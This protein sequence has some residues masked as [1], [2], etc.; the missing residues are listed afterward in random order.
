MKCVLKFLVFLILSDSTEGQ[1]IIENYFRI[2][3]SLRIGNG[4]KDF[5]PY[6]ERGYTLILPDSAKEINGVIISLEDEKFDLKNSSPQIYSEAKL[7]GFAVLYISTGV[8]VDLYFSPNQLVSI[9]SVIKQ[10]F[11]SYDLPNKNIFFLGVSLAGQIRDNFAESSIF[12][13]KLVTYLL[14][15][16][17][18]GTPKD[19]LEKYLSF[20][21]YSYFD[22]SSRH[23]KY[24]K[25][26]AFRAYSEPATYYWL[27]AKRKT[28]FD[29]NFPDMVGIIMN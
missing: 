27:Q 16:N 12:E 15:K 23:I 14:E 5:I 7:K 29:T 3:D 4:K 9:D 24:F 21:P 18:G 2:N 1:K 11:S 8:P 6:N 19:Q 10:V 25:D 22:E 13:A 20:S 26:Y 28:T 17:F